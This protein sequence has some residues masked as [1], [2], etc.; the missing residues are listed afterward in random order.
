MLQGTRSLQNNELDHF[1][2]FW[3]LAELWSV[4]VTFEEPWDKGYTSSHLAHTLPVAEVWLATDNTATALVVANTEATFAS[5][6]AA[7]VT[8]AFEDCFS[9]VA[10]VAI[11]KPVIGKPTKPTTDSIASMAANQ[12]WSIATK[13]ANQE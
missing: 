3:G 5:F 11:A 4:E 9:V 8:V 13:A 1:S 12:E 6:V 2:T 7:N 10:R